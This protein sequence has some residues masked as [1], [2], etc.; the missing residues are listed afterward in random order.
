M[1]VKIYLS[2]L[3]GAVF[4]M[5]SMLAQTK[6]ISG[7]VT[8]QYDLPL[9]GVNILVK[10]TTTGTQS[11]FDGNYTI[12]A[13]VGQTLLFSYLGLRTEEVL[14]GSSSTIN[15]RMEEDA[16]AL[17]E[18]VLTALGLEKKK[19]EDLSSST[20]VDT[21]ALQRSG[22]SGLIQGM[23]GKT[24]GLLITRNTGD[25]GA[26]A[27]IQIRGQNTITGSSSPLVIIDGI[28]ISNFSSTGGTGGV[29]QQSRLNDIN[30]DDIENITVLK[31]A[32]AAAVYGSGAAN[33][34]IVIKTKGA[35]GAEGKVTVNI[36]SSTAIDKINIEHKKQGK[37]GQGFPLWWST[38]D[39]AD[40]ATYVWVPNTGFSWGDKIADRNGGDDDV[41]VGNQ[42]FEAESGNIYYPIV[43]KNSQEVFNKTNRDQVFGNGLTLDNSI[44][45]GFAGNR[46]RTLL[47]YSNWDQQGII[48]GQS[49]YNRQTFRINNDLELSDKVRARV[50]VA[51]TKIKSQSVQQGSNLNGL[52]LGYLRTSPDY[53]NTDYKGTYFNSA[54]VPTANSHRGY[55]NYLGSAPPAYNNPGWTINEQTNP[56]LVDRFI[57]NPELNW[58]IFKNIT[59]TTRY[60]LDYYVDDRESFFPVNSAG[61]SSVGGYGKT[62]IR[63]KIEN[64]DAFLTAQHI[65]DPNFNIS[66]IAGVN[67]QSSLR[68]SDGAGETNFT[69]PFVGDLR[70]TG[71]STA[72]NNAGFVSSR[73]VRKSGVYGVF[74]T[75]LFDQ[76]L[77]ELSGRYERPSTLNDGVFYPS[78]SIGWQFS[79]ALGESNFFS[80]GKF[81][82]SYGEVGIEP[83]PYSGTTLFFGGGAGST[84]GDGLAGSLYGNPFTRS[85]TRGNP[86]LKPEIVKEYEVGMDARFLNNRL[87][88]NATYYS[89][90]TVDALLSIA[91]PA[92]TGFGSQLENAAEISNKGVEIDLG[93]KIISTNDFSWDINL[94][95]STNRNIVEDLSGVQSVFLNGFTGS[96][97]RVIEGEP[98][99]ALWG[100]KFQRNDDGSLTLDENGF[101]IADSQEGIIGDPNPDWRGGLGTTLRW[102]GLTLS[103]QFETSQGGDMW[104]GTKGVL[105]Y[106]GISPDTAN[107]SVAPA[108]GLTN[109]YGVNYPE[110]TI[111]RGNIGDF[112]GGP[113]ALDADWYSDLGGGFGAVGE[114]FVEDASWTRLRELSLFYTIPQRLIKNIG[115][116]NMEIG[117]TGRNLALWTKFEG[118]DPDLNLT[119]ASKGRGLDYFTN[120]GTKSYLFTIKVGF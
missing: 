117:V 90:R 16:Q 29:A 109:Y 113:V 105:Y 24:S 112:G 70:L 98:F 110:G 57:I 26:G 107:E 11:D 115:F 13:A 114:Q 10:G 37:Y 56:N 99:S 59:L 6:T 73:K 100:G 93:G 44:N 14:V 96:S 35:K 54:G 40:A 76:L 3:A 116:A 34:V 7:T 80:F 18:V 50:N 111:F 94:N 81:R 83:Q 31:G 32:S 119:G 22:E 20:R 74:N 2:L 88:L 60:G 84:W 102:K 46:S 101:P 79:K 91:L 30:P 63:S 78:A 28:P 92:S 45:I 75:E 118:V 64:Y 36:R 5:T 17:Q 19:D 108:G 21:E 95:F 47:S 38:G 9:P 62:I 67:F 4:G 68:R 106:F 61:A 69:N 65:I 82:A 27:Y 41:S 43:N 72:E 49:A 12:S 71:N 33:G 97:A 8:D 89:R 85:A 23:A 52:Y 39:P 103:A 120:P 104:A 25:P 66:W 53:D 86:N 42:R 15:I 1:K 87:S 77:I 58:D 48:Q 51:Y 55:R